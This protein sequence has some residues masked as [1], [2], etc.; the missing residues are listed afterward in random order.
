MK[1]WYKDRI[2]FIDTNFLARRSSAARRPISAG[3]TLTIT[4]PAGATIYYTLNGTD[5]VA[6]RESSPT[7]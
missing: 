7:R 3:F 5:R 1:Q 4:G 6:G 2:N